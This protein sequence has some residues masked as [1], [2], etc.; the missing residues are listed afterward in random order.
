MPKKKKINKQS[1]RRAK[2]A[3]PAELS[4]L[5]ADLFRS[6]PEKKYTIKSLASA[7]GGAAEA[8]NEAREIV[9]SLMA[10]GVVEEVVDGKFRLRRT[11]VRQNLYTGV[12]DMLTSGSMYVRV[13]GLENDIFI[14]QRL[15]RHALHG[16]KVEVSLLR[17]ARGGA[18][19]GEVVRVVERSR[20]VYAGRAEV[21]G[22]YAF[23]RVDSRKMPVDVFIPLEGAPKVE[24]NQKVAV[25]VVD[26]PDTMKNPLGEIV[27]VLGMVGENDAEMHAILTEYDLPY[28]FEAEVIAAADSIPDDINPGEVALRR[29]MRGVPTFTIDP[30]DA[31]DFDD[32]LS[33][34]PLRE[35]VWEV[36]VH[37]ADVTHYVREGSVVDTEGY[38]RATSVYL[39]DRTVPMLPERLSNEL[40][41]L[42]PDEDKLCFSAVFEIDAEC[43]ILNQWLGRTV[44]RSVRR[45]AYEQAQQV[46][47][48]GQGDYKDEILTLNALAQRMRAGRFKNGS[49]TFEREEAKFKLDEN[50]KP[51]GVYFKEQKESNQLIEEFMLLANRTV[52]EFI[53]RKRGEGANAQRTMVYRV[54]DKPNEEKLG[55]FASFILRFGYTFRLGQGAPKV[56]PQMN[57][58]M[59]EI[60]G[61]AEENV[62]STLAIR[63]MAKAYYSTDNIGHYG[64]SFP[65]YTH[66]TSP[67][68]RYP[69]MMVHRLLAHYLEGGQSP[70]KAHFETLCEHCSEME[71]RAA[72]AERASIRY[73]MVE[74]MLDRIGEQFDGTISGVTEWGV[75]V[76][77]TDT[78]IEGMATVR[79][80][81][82][83][84]YSFSE[85]DY[86]IVGR[87]TGRMFTLGDRVRIEV[88]RADL[89]R[90]QLDF[91]I[92]ASYDFDSGEAFAVLPPAAPA[93]WEKSKFRKRR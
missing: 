13:E 66:F 80:M 19:E 37:I 35:G 68:R 30:A 71:V 11:Q 24:N 92:T 6:F 16:D 56:A 4:A 17:R 28:R 39:V 46:I 7:L 58:L 25:R 43:N 45:F 93:A 79:D 41:S 74:F 2:L 20:K 73:K 59:S 23:I 53:G 9:N 33:I 88:L 47:E 44:I 36:G 26:W 1:P 83:D 64:L 31:K 76:E 85:E 55:R 82:D 3:K 60:R 52:A 29:D 22:R 78:H 62:I 77:L 15:T 40:C 49:I 84:F 42:R 27:D 32:A 34:R 38:D 51:L 81:I 69:D 21:T 54:H 89:A 18:L 67:I 48:T 86:A 63:T 87:A 65:F 14:N 61:K 90:K 57:K 70:D 91:R 10:Q 72:E 5:V 8:R 50:G 75:Y 12:A